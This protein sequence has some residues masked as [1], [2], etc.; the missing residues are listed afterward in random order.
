MV[1]NTSSPE[2]NGA[3]DEDN[4]SSGIAG[5]DSG[6]EGTGAASVDDAGS[7]EGSVGSVQAGRAV[8]SMDSC[9]FA[10]RVNARKITTTSTDILPTIKRAFSATIAAAGRANKSAER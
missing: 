10:A 5:S 6:T 3:A 7:V 4:G 1:G 8:S 9:A 2:G